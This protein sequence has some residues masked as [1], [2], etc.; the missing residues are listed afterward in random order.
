MCSTILL[1]ALSAVS[2]HKCNGC[3]VVSD[4]NGGCHGCVVSYNGCSACSCARAHKCGLFKR[5]FSKRCH[6][7]CSCSSDCNGCSSACHGGWGC[8]RAR[9]HRCC[10]PACC[11]VVCSGCSAPA[12]DGGCAAPDCAAAPEGSTEPPPAAPAPMGETPQTESGFKVDRTIVAVSH[13][14]ER[15]EFSD[16]PVVVFA[17]N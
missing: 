3:A 16:E 11:E 12:C 4:C 5:L 15:A 6:G 14:L 17:R 8:H 13:T 1:V 10:R 9:K 7:A 2:G